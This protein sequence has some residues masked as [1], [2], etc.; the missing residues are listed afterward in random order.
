MT[1]Q[2]VQLQAKALN[3]LTPGHSLDVEV[4]PGAAIIQTYLA[5]PQA[6]VVDLYHG[7]PVSAVLDILASGFRGTPC[8]HGTPGFDWMRQLPGG[9]LP[10]LFL[11][12]LER[13]AEG[14]PQPRRGE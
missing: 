13:C 9:P 3:S 12:A 11:S 7:C 6:D 5:D 1:V 14:Y 10:V 4:H 8:T 2:D